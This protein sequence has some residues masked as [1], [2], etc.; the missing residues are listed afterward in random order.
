MQLQH[1]LDD[2]RGR[3]GVAEAPAGHGIRLG[4][5]IDHNG[6][7]PHAGQRGNRAMRLP[8]GQLG[9]NL[10]REHKQ[11][12]RLQK[13][14]NLFEVFA[15]HDSAG[16]VVRVGEHQHFGAGGE[17][18]REQLGRYFELVLRLCVQRHGNAA[19]HL[20]QR[21]IAD[22]AGLGHDHLVAGVNDGAE[23]H[24][25]RL[26][27]ADGDENLGLRLIMQAEAAVEIGGDACAQLGQTAV[28]GIVGLV[29]DNRIHTCVGD[30]IGR[31]KIR[32]PD[33]ERNHILP[34][35]EHIKELADAGRLDGLHLV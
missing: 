23:R 27:A 6:T 22:K 19:H 30:V 33:G 16:R 10:I 4:E 35:A 20:N 2:R 18:R 32:L 9:V 17:Q 12:V 3:A 25:N 34:P 1:L 29:F 24:V 26:A 8:I 7:L 15:G 14:Q 5:P 28:G 31:R 11:V 13:R 21:R